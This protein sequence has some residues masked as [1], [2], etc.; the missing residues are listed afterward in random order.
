MVE[1]NFL[2]WENCRIRYLAIL[3]EYINEYKEYFFGFKNLTFGICENPDK[4]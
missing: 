4:K 2:V 3:M 1:L